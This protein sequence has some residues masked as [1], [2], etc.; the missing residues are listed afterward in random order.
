[1]LRTADALKHCRRALQQHPLGSHGGLQRNADRTRRASQVRCGC[2]AMGPGCGRTGRA[3]CKGDHP[4]WHVGVG[5]LDCL[6]V[7]TSA[8]YH[9]A[10]RDVLVSC[11]CSCW[12]VCTQ[13]NGA[14]VLNTHASHARLH[15]HARYHVGLLNVLSSASPSPSTSAGRNVF[16]WVHGVQCAYKHC[17]VDLGQPRH[18]GRLLQAPAPARVWNL[19]PGKRRA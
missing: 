16:V 7:L 10:R 9:C 15:A 8:F 4:G 1:M 3:N 17:H 2:S 12:L 11:S 19:L 5:A 18:G 13:S 14:T 6:F